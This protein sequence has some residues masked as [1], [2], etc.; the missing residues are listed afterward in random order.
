MLLFTGIANAQVSSS[1][2]K[3]S[4]GELVPVNS[5]WSLLLPY[6]A[7]SG[8]SCVQVNNSG[9]FSV[10]G[11]PCGGSGSTPGGSS[12]QVQYNAN[13]TF[14]GTPTTT[15]SAGTGVSFST[16]TVLG[17]TPVVITSTGA[18]TFGSTSISAIGP[19]L[20]NSALAQISTSF[21]TSTQNSFTAQNIFTSL[22]ATL[23]STTNATTTNLAIVGVGA[24]NCNSTSALTT[25]S[26][27]VVGC[28]A[29]P[30][31]TV[32]S[33]TGTYPV[34]STGG[35]TPAISLA[36]G[37]TT[38]NTWAGT[39][40]FTNSPIFS[41][42]TTGGTVN[43]NTTGSLYTSA[44]TTLSGTANQ[45]TVSNSPVIFGN[46]PSVLSLPSLV[47]FPSNASTTDFSTGYGS[48]TS[49][50][51]GTLTLPL[52]TGTNCLQEVNGVVGSAGAACGSGSGGV[53]TIATSSL[54]TA[55]Q[56]GYFTTTS[57]YPARESGEATGTITGTANQITVTG[58]G[59]SLLGNVAFSLPAQVNLT[60]ITASGGATSTSFQNANLAS[61][62][63]L[64]VSSL[65]TGCLQASAGGTVSSTGSGCGSSSGL[66]SYDAF[67]H[68]AANQSATTS[69]MISTGG[70]LVNSASSTISF[71]S[72]GNSTTTNATTTSLAVT[73]IAA[74]NLLYTGTGGSVG[75]LSTTSTN[76]IGL[77]P[78]LKTWTVAANGGGDFTTIQAALTA[79]GTS[80]TGGIIYLTDSS[81]TIASTLT[82]PGSFCTLEGNGVTGTTINVPGN[83][84]TTAIKTSA[85]ASQWTE[86]GLD[87]LYFSQTNGTPQGVCIDLSN[88]SFFS[89]NHVDC[90]NFG[91]DLR[92]NDTQNITFYDT[93][94]NFLGQIFTGTPTA[95]TFGINA[96][97]TDPSNDNNFYNVHFALESTAANAGTCVSLN[98]NQAFQF[99]GL[100]CEPN[101][102][103]NEYGVVMA[104]S[105][106]AGGTNNGTF[107]NYIS[108]Y[109]EEGATK[110]S[111]KIGTTA[112][113]GALVMNNTFVNA[114]VSDPILDSSQ[115]VDTYIGI[116]NTLSSPPLAA[117]FPGLISAASS[118]IGAGGKT[119]GLTI[120][121]GSTTTLLAN[122]PG[123][124]ISHVTSGTTVPIIA[125][126]DS[127][128]VPIALIAEDGTNFADTSSV[129]KF[130]DQNSSDSG[131]TVEISNAGTGNSIQVENATKNLFVVTAA[132]IASTTNLNI[133]ALGTP[134]GSF[135]AVNQTGQVIA[136][137]TP[138][139]GGGSLTGTTGQVAYFSGTN[140]AVGTSS[141]FI[142]S[143]KNVGVGTTT[144]GS[145]FSVQGNSLFSGNL[146]LAALNATSSINTS[147]TTGGYY[148]DNN[149]ILQASSSLQDTYVGQQA[150]NTSSGSA[151]QNVAVGYQ[152]LQNLTNG[153]HDTAVG[154][155][156]MQNI[157]TSS[158]LTAIGYNVLSNATSS[159]NFMIGIGEGALQGASVGGAIVN[160][161]DMIGI[162]NDAL[163]NF[164]NAFADDAVGDDAL[165]NLTTGSYDVAVGYRVLQDNTTGQ[166]DTG[167]GEGIME[168]FISG[169]QNSG[170][171]NDALNNLVTG[172]NNSAFGEDAL[173]NATTTSDNTAA[174][175]GALNGNT[176]G[177]YTITGNDDAAVG[178][179]ALQNYITNNNSTAM[180]FK[181]IN[182]ASSSNDN[183]AF[184]Y[185]AMQGNT[186]GNLTISGNQNTVIGENSLQNYIAASSNSTLGF[187]AGNNVSS[188]SNNII[189]GADPSKLNT[190]S[191]GSNN[192][193]LGFG[194][195]ATTSSATNSLN[196]GNIL[197]G[198]G[199]TSGSAASTNAAIGIGTST[200]WG[201]FSLNP[202][203]IGAGPV[204]AIGSTT[205]TLL[206]LFA[207]G[208]TTINNAYGTPLFQINGASTTA[209]QLIVQATSTGNT[210]FSID[211]Y[212][213]I[214]ASSTGATP[215]IACSPSGGTITAGSNDTTGDFTTGTLSTSC[216]ITYA[217]A[218]PVTPE[219]FLQQSGTVVIPGVSSRST[220]GF[221][222]SLSATVTGDN[223]SYFT[224]QP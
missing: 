96:S 205:N 108:G 111:I 24:I 89:I 186:S 142:T 214:F 213:G 34:Q 137:T 3:L 100:T 133:S 190:L 51:I 90:D 18:S 183:T 70:I 77:S 180:G 41:T 141:L 80:G 105:S 85:A 56:I 115:S 172:N 185:Q 50:F 14:G 74:K 146:N 175:F 29:Q 199:L 147:G 114:Q 131:A 102:S 6:L 202:N 169:N 92:F 204:F 91:T 221:T 12:G 35:V 208:S 113:G 23:A 54:E 8:T 153:Q 5:S 217:S 160:G 33:V 52:L 139:G 194:T 42:L 106:A 116:D 72:I 7:G 165:Q 53:G 123:G 1:L 87:H 83:T 68:P 62:T 44:T 209:P 162:G 188:G 152:S 206:T 184:G 136:T 119:T 4:S 21:S 45:L 145:L 173:Q 38:S 181:S 22:F 2:W 157:T 195:S 16:F 143:N 57:G 15:V 67:T 73:N 63:N 149:L 132:G 79:C 39:Q 103:T 93:I 69:L 151:N 86:D 46:T 25:N 155:Q 110:A 129:A 104:S 197:Y 179:D 31:G 120:N 201:Y 192:I 219:V 59:Y 193:I 125:E 64:I 182:N 11:S 178:E 191:T 224:I 97:S 20:W 156:N 66:S 43:A 200:P 174:G 122:F 117:L 140:T 81:Y 121:G 222:V 61:T 99:F 27:G 76:N 82:I 210:L 158:H 189:I 154:F 223:I 135:L 10:T 168:N 128:G 17:S 198:T 40:T 170:F 212:G 13:G 176:N 196:I 95:P 32:T 98:N 26:S 148:I 207:N 71:L 144:P 171:G 126:S 94:Q 177:N 84:V 134:A 161:G 107:D 60:N 88:M 47:I 211:Q 48:T 163:Q 75:G 49:A 215:T 216:T 36:F 58:T 109:Y 124:L 130:L 78:R 118:T 127:S 28:T 159:V 65:L 218:K 138:S 30:Q 112:T 203:G 187:D 220:T 19:I 166:F 101:D 150:G 37:T 55:G 164:T 9:D 167:V